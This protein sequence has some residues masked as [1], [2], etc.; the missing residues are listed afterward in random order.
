MSEFKAEFVESIQR[1][2][3]IK[4]FR[5]KT[6]GTLSFLPGQ[7]A[8]IVFDRENPG[9]KNLNKYLSFSSAPGKEYFEIT[10]RI[11]NSD[12]SQ[13]LLN[14]TSGD[15]LLFNGP[16]GNCT[17]NPSYKKMCFL[18]GGIGI[19]PVISMLEHL[20]EKKIDIEAELAY[21]NSTEE[22]IAFKAELDSWSENLENIKVM[23][24]V[25]KCEP[26]D[27]KCFQGIIDDS[28]LMKNI[29]ICENKIIFSFGPP[30]MVLAMKELALK[31][32]CTEDRVK[33]ENFVGY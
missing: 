31:A 2:E 32:G 25:N 9:N 16:L 10:K 6:E 27:K 12:F 19:T 18:V 4:S 13:K 33:I 29:G 22:D 14:L 11:S 26:R 21:S 5:F 7:F 8:K 15:S 3:S 24:L 28:F 17:L 1:T 23:Y 30:A 20:V